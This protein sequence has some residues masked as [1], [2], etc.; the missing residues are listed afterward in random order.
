MPVSLITGNESEVCMF[1]ARKARNLAV[2]MV[3]K[4][5][6]DVAKDGGR[7]FRLGTDDLEDK[8]L[9]EHLLKLG[10]KIDGHNLSW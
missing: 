10:Y 3:L 7:C 1:C 5:I 6:K 9:I 8:E 4:D 2:K